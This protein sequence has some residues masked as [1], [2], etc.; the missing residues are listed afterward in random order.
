M[1]R[2][3]LSRSSQPPAHSS[4]AFEAPPPS[5][6]KHS[7][8]APLRRHIFTMNVV[9]QDLLDRA[10][11]EV[12]LTIMGYDA[13]GERLPIWLAQKKRALSLILTG[14]ESLHDAARLQRDFA[15]RLGDRSDSEGDDLLPPPPLVS[16]PNTPLTPYMDDSPSFAP[17]SPSPHPSLNT[18]PSS[19][20]G[21][22]IP[23]P[24][25]PHRAETPPLIVKHLPPQPR[26]AKKNDDEVIL[27]TSSSEDENDENFSP[28]PLD[29]IE[30]F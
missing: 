25:A 8:F 18:P 20:D 10:V 19:P 1:P 9:N 22:E 24:F 29:D 30:D 17:R 15:I 12:N 2:P 7:Y 26:P 28:T 13:R 3:R 11:S 4:F 21:A 27:L 6:L 14:L 23:Y 5:R 16:T